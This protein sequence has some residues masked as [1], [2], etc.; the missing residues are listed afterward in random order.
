MPGFYDDMVA[1]G[2]IQPSPSPLQKTRKKMAAGGALKQD[3]APGDAI[4]A[5]RQRAADLYSQG[6]AIY[7]QDPDMSALQDFARQRSG[8]GD[9]AMF[10]AMAA[11]LAGPRFDA[12][13]TQYLKKAAAAADPI[14]MGS[15]MITADGQYIKDPEV[16]QGRKA[17][18]LMNQAK[19]YEQLAQQGQIAQDRNETNV[20]LKTL[21][22]N[23]KQ[24]K[25]KQTDAQFMVG[26]KR[27]SARFNEGDGV[28]ELNTPQGWTPAPP[29]ARRITVSTGGALPSGQY[30]KL[31]T[32]LQA[33]TN[34]LTKLNNYFNTV[35]NADVGIARQADKIAANF[36]S[37]FG[38]KLKP[39]ELAA[40][41][42]QG[43]LQ[44]LIGAFRTE[45]VGPGVMTEQDAKRVI[46]AL[47]G[48]FGALSNPQ[49]VRELL[50]NVYRSKMERAQI[51]QQ[52][53]ERNAPFF[54]ETPPEL[55]LPATLGGH[56]PSE[57]GGGLSA[58]QQRRLQ[59]L[60]AKKARGEL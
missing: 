12:M 25:Y 4:S 6:S 50:S 44:G 13:Q 53:Y 34:G 37:L 48:D 31:K 5:Y 14:K 24:P 36:K 26:G 20:L 18:F 17:E 40:Q 19:A 57:G 43:Q 56:K 51:M 15:G 30:L 58:D 46:D 7:D 54:S 47:G 1:N 29:E 60:R 33:E 41:V 52:E 23:N 39:K 21:A 9:S 55:D 2:A 49:V 10:N 42:G 28:Y 27:Y 35:G 32:D 22:A 38:G 59:E 3:V 16:A 11:S 8:E 45:V